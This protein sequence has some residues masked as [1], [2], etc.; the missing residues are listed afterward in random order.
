MRSLLSTALLALVLPLVLATGTLAAPVTFSQ[1]DLGTDLTFTNSGAASTL[2]ETSQVNL[3]C[4]DPACAGVGT[5]ATLTLSAGVS[6]PAGSFG[7]FDVQPLG[8]GTLT[9]TL[10]TPYLGKT[11]FLAIGFSGASILGFDGG[12]DF[13][14]TSS[15]A[16]TFSSDF[17]NYTDVGFQLTSADADPALGIDGNGYLESFTSDSTGSFFGTPSATPVPASLPLFATGL[18]AL[19]LFGWRKQRKNP[20]AIVAA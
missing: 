5:A 18:G 6:G 11:N 9:V 12:P 19:G 13:S 4:L 14:I 2:S 10:D 8:A 3:T 7:P 16:S 15:G 1:F 20:A 17:L